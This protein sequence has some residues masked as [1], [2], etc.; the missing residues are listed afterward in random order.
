VDDRITELAHELRTPLTGILGVIDL[1]T[2]S[3]VPL[4]E[5]ETAELLAVAR[6]EANHLRAIIDG[7]VQRTRLDSG[8][9]RAEKRP[10]SALQLVEEALARFPS[11]SDRTSI[12][13]DGAAVL[14]TDPSL[15]SQILTN[16]FQN[17]NRYAPS[18]PVFVTVDREGDMVGV[19]VTDSGPGLPG[20]EVPSSQG[21]GVGL[22]T[23]RRLA[24]LLGGSL[25]STPPPDG[26]G[27]AFRLELPASDENVPPTVGDV[28]AVPPRAR[29]LQEVAD[30]L[31][32]TSLSRIM[33]GVGRL[34][35]EMLGAATVLVFERRPTDLVLHRPDGNNSVFP[36]DDVAGHLVGL[37][38]GEVSELGDRPPWLADLE[39]QEVRV[40]TMRS[41]E[42]LE[43]LL[44]VGWRAGSQPGFAA[45]VLP[46][47]AALALVGIDRRSLGAELDFERR[48]RAE[49]MDS[50]PIAISVFAG[51]PP[52]LISSNR[53]EREMLALSDDAERPEELTASQSRFEVR[54]EDGTPLDGENAPV[55]ETIR[56]GRSTG[57]FYLRI[58]RVDGTEV[59]T[60][61]HCAPV[62]GAGGEVLG[63]VVTS[64]AIGD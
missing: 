46:A 53:A 60:R 19:T 41:G 50:L 43:G 4:D 28:V 63:A 25:E 23:S 34:G 22:S 40:V 64:E 57:P 54:F 31:V 39:D 48:V 44:V 2:A 47:L 12:S 55:V 15:A 24:G 3:P 38:N 5:T 13:G 8:T 27:A 61:T 52:R 51:D 18:G 6:A 11:V 45:D 33:T 42:E 32:G 59:V 16:L 36:L 56:T 26:T 10:V 37:P 1:V 62:R 7:V 9:L 29:L 20:G 30:L 58:R 21:L 35:R 49:V 17:I 14:S